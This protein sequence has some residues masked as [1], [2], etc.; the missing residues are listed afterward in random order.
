MSSMSA[1]RTDESC[2]ND[3]SLHQDQAELIEGEA[4]LQ[5]IVIE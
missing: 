4:T 2:K 3:V 1:A 5:G